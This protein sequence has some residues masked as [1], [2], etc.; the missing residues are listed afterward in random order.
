MLVYAHIDPR[1]EL[2]FYIGKGT[3]ERAN[4][5]RRRSNFY[6]KISGKIFS[7]GMTPLVRILH[8]DLTENEAFEKERIEISFYGRRNNGTG[9]LVN[10]TDGGEGVSG[11]QHSEDAKLRIGA[12]KK[13]KTWGEISERRKPKPA[14]SSETIEK[15]QRSRA[16]FVKRQAQQYLEGRS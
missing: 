10:L 14:M 13:N 4:D 16:A 2:P 8:D 3:L 9:I 1:T 15:M 6:K 5:F 11:F 7:C 12:A